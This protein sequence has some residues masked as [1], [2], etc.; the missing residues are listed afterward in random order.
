VQLVNELAQAVTAQ[1][2]LGEAV[3]ISE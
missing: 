3:E 1:D 2:W